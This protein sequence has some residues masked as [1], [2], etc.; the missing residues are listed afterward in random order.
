MSKMT[1]ATRSSLPVSKMVNKMPVTE[2]GKLSP[3]MA[4]RIRSKVSKVLGK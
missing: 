2:K 1:A 3:A 4:S